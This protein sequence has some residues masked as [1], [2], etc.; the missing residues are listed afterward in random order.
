MFALAANE[1]FQT[2][3]AVRYLQCRFF[4]T[5]SNI[6]L[7]LRKYP[8]LLF[9]FQDMA[10]SNGKGG[11]ISSAICYLIDLASYSCGFIA[12]EW[13]VEMDS[14]IVLFNIKEVAEQIG[15][16]PATI[17]NWE[18]QGLFKAK[19]GKNRY[20]LFDFKDVEFLRKLKEGSKDA[21]MGMNAL[22]MLYAADDAQATPTRAERVSKKLLGKKWR[23]YRVRKGC[24]LEEVAAAVGISSSYLSK[25]ENASSDMNVSLNILQRLARYY[26]ENLLYYIDDDVEEKAVVKKGEG[27]DLSIG[28]EGVIVKSLV[29]RKNTGISPMLYTIE[30]GAG[31]AEPSVH[32]GEEFVYVLRGAVSFFLNDGQEFELSAGDSLSF[33][34]REPHSWINRGNEEAKLL[35]VYIPAKMP[36]GV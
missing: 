25:I 1:L 7:M 5:L 13:G 36:S 22:R 17:R 21:S 10:Y 31:R 15:V 30:P 26:G 14:D 11:D 28:V 34:S 23:E 16:V 20:R 29:A 18:K 12:R 24:L 27:E 4:L 3:L 32:T 33:H 9:P 8:I 2:L 6:F 19:R 35:W